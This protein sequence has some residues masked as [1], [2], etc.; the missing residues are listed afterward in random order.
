MYELD[1]I[2]TPPP[3]TSDP[4]FEM[5]QAWKQRTPQGEQRTQ[6]VA[7]VTHLGYTQVIKLIGVYM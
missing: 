1:A 4:A 2:V 7:A 3:P 5:L 6:L